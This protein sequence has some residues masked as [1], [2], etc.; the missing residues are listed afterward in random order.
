ML[1]FI[2]WDHVTPPPVEVHV[3]LAKVKELRGD[4]WHLQGKVHVVTV[5]AA[6]SWARSRPPYRP[7][8]SAWSHSA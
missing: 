2:F 7:L 5:T 3:L 8:F 1:S 6:N 4:A